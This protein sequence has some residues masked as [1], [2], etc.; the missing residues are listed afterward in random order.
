[1]D[2]RLESNTSELER[3]VDQ[4]E[5]LLSVGRGIEQKLVAVLRHLEAIEDAARQANRA[6]WSE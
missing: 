3:L 5:A 1:M 4:A 6:Q 2:D